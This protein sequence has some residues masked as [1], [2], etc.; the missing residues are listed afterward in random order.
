MTILFDL[1]HVGK[2]KESSKKV[3]LG[4]HLKTATILKLLDNKTVEWSKRFSLVIN[5]I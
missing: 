1:K 3:L 2:G 5:Y 4:R